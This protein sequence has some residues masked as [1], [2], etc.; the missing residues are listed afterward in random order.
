MPFRSV[1][2]LI[3]ILVFSSSIAAAPG[4]D[5]PLWLTQ[6]AGASV[7]SYDK[8]VPAVVLYI[9]Q[10]MAVGADG[11]TTTVTN[12]AVRVLV[13]EGRYYA[14]A[15]QVYLTNSSKVRELRAWLITPGGTVKKYG[16]DQ[17]VDVIA[18]P[19]DIY[20][21]VRL[22]SISAGDD[23][24]VGSVFGYE[25]ISE[26]RPL[27]QQDQWMFQDRLPTLLS[28]YTL[29]LPEGWRAN[30]VTFN[31]ESVEPTVSGTSYKWELRNLGPIPRE[32][33]SPKVNNLVP[34]LAINYFLPDSNAAPGFRSFESWTQVSRWATE[35]HDP[36]S[37][38]DE[39][40]TAKAKQLTANAT[41]ELDKIRAIAQFVQKLQYISID[42]GIGKGNGYRP[43][44]ASQ[45]LAKAYGDCKDKAN[46]MRTLLKSIGI[47]AYPIAIYSGDATHV[48]EQWPSPDQFNHCIIA[49]KVSDET[50]AD[51]VINHPALGR[52]LIFDATDE[53]TPVGDLPDHEQGSLAL[54]IAGDQ[55]TL[56]KM[57]VMPPESSQL[58][59]EANVLL[60]PEGAITAT[61]K[62]RSIGQTAVEERRA[63]KKL[64]APGYRHMIEEWVTRGATTARI[65]RIEPVDDEAGGR[66]GLDVEFS[67]A[68]YAQLMQQKLLVFN[69]AIVSRREALFLTEPSRKH[70]IVLESHAFT[71]KVRVRLPAGFLVDELPDAVKLDTPFGSYK[72]SYEVKDGELFFVR[73]LSQRGAAIPADQ[74]QAVRTFYEKIRAAEQAPVV[75]AR[76]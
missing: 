59:R 71:E 1:L 31:R 55:G 29:T 22:K 33:A 4:D 60:T 14:S 7:P 58:E 6:A 61:I 48:T 54:L 76:Q 49:V 74:Y 23:A 32:V 43:H 51:T 16:K 9:D 37:L 34:R 18:D 50:R 19:N 47:V 12:F 28:R 5:V 25:A 21:E 13:R 40:I 67:A 65:S 73:A 63:F 36:Q 45:V 15:S 27:F 53:H 66:F 24:E 11:R 75:L 30:S 2:V 17:V 8:D 70:P 56:T 41:T 69:P 42:I 64:S 72:T 3:S 46:L 52:L 38:V 57:P 35:L 20:N 44:P 26:E 10:S 68:A 62:E 39:N